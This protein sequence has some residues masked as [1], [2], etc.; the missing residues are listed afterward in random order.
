MSTQPLLSVQFPSMV[1]AVEAPW[2][3][4]QFTGLDVTTF[5]DVGQPRC[6]SDMSLQPLGQFALAN[7][8]ATTPWLI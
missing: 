3:P 8:T 1:I 7:P 2:T 4:F 5:G 6:D